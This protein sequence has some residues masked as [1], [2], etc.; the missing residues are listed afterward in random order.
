MGIFNIF[1]AKKKPIDYHNEVR[2]NHVSVRWNIVLSWIPIL[3]ILA[4]L[5]IGKFWVSWLANLV[6]VGAAIPGLIIYD[7]TNI[8]I[9]KLLGIIVAAIGFGAFHTYIIK[10]WTE[11]WNKKVDEFNKE[12]YQYHGI[13]SEEN[14][15]NAAKGFELYDK[16]KIDNAIKQFEQILNEEPNQSQALFGIAKSLVAQGNFDEAKIYVDKLRIRF[17]DHPTVKELQEI[18]TRNTP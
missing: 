13:A 8:D 15:I 18:L 1:G 9:V 10:T 5:S 3:N 2:K 7:S 11:E 12:L 4:Y 17:P 16:G 6:A 14:R